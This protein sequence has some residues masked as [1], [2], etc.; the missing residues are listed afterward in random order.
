MKKN[1]NDLHNPAYQAYADM[2]RSIEN[3][4]T[5]PERH[6][7]EQAQGLQCAL[8]D[9]KQRLD[10]LRVDYAATIAQANEDYRKIEHS[11]DPKV[12]E[13]LKRFDLSC[14]L[15]SLDDTI[16]DAVATFRSS[17]R[18]GPEEAGADNDSDAYERHMRRETAPNKF[19]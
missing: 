8:H 13:A 17:K 18:M 19:I 12:N 2:L 14:C 1:S 4:F 5:A 6:S 15:E 11:T 16:A 3:T 7:A 9:L 10:R